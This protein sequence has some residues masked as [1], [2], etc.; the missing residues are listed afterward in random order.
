M[1][2]YTYINSYVAGITFE[3]FK[4]GSVKVVKGFYAGGWFFR[5]FKWIRAYIK[6]KIMQSKKNEKLY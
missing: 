3:N 1:I 6:K 2:C 5:D 4:V